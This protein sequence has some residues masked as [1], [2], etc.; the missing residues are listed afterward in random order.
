M[1][2]GGEGS[3][4]RLRRK[5]LL[6][7]ASVAILALFISIFGGNLGLQRIFV[8]ASDSMAP[9]LNRG[10]L[11]FASPFSSTIENGTLV[12]FKSP[13]NGY[14]T[15]RISGSVE[16]AQ[17]TYYL[18]KGDA[19]A[20]V[21]S[22]LIPEKSVIGPV[23][24]II[25][26]IGLFFM[27]PREI[28]LAA[29]IVA[30]VLYVALTFYF[31]RREEPQSVVAGT[32]IAARAAKVSGHKLKLAFTALLVVAM[33]V[34]GGSGQSYA[35]LSLVYP[36]SDA[37]A[38]I[39]SP[40]VVL[41]QGTAGSSTI[42]AEGTQA[43]VSGIFSG[44]STYSNLTIFYT[45]N[46]SSGLLYPKYT[47]WNGSAWLAPEG[48]LPSAG[49]SIQ[50][51][52]AA[53]CPLSSRPYEVIVVTCSNDSAL[54]AF[55]WNG[56]SWNI[57][58]DIGR[59]YAGASTYEAYDLAY[60]STSGRAVLVYATNTTD[61]TKDMAYRIWN[62]TAWSAEAYIDAPTGINQIK[63]RWIFLASN[64]LVGSNEIALI[65]LDGAN[66][67]I[68]GGIWNGSSW[69]QVF[70]L[71]RNVLNLEL[72]F[73][74]VSVAYLHHICQPIFAWGDGGTVKS[75]L[76]N[77]LSLQLLPNVALGGG[78]KVDWLSLK[79]DHSSNMIML[80]V[81]DTS[82]SLSTSLFDGTT[83]VSTNAVIQATGLTHNATRCAEFEWEPTG[84]KGL[85]AFSIAAGSVSYKTFSAPGTWSATSSLSNAGT[86]PWIQ[87]ERN[88][89]NIAGDYKI[90]GATLNNYSALY[91]FS[92]NGSVLS[93][94]ADS[95]TNNSGTVAYKCFDMALTSAF[96]PASSYEYVLKVTNLASSAL[97]IRLAAYSSS[98]LSRI[99]N[100]TICIHDGVNS[101][102]IIV[103][104]GSY[105]LQNGSWYALAASSVD[106]VSVYISPC[107]PGTTAIYAYLE[108]RAPG[109]GVL[110]RY[111]V[112]F[113]IA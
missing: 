23:T 103:D 43:N 34:A 93:L 107:S 78:K 100:L 32:S 109:C 84:S 33:V 47:M 22:I 62:G 24:T 63:T 49:S 99:T 42:S 83:W 10:D 101:S 40:T 60:E 53:Y 17:G 92:W 1:A 41:Q 14:Q 112:N 75:R 8:I 90:M 35:S 113:Y 51:L 108:V 97:E 20:Q 31:G 81:I 52:R 11:V 38:S 61:R 72:R 85:L 3:A 105:S 110:V 86:H 15:H 4:R 59:M 104:A 37:S 69:V 91:A 27:I 50:W 95:L 16:T 12:V 80:T 55:V 18:T 6:L 28:F 82:K 25:P 46:T 98:N 66:K 88:P 58:P 79:A 54:D 39:T 26:T 9:T 45:S 87:L 74:S 96:R 94:K 57:S 13:L 5:R 89:R 64:P 71:D 56:T 21:D 65:T 29:A 73:D 19:N 68:I 44:N 2:Y 7:L 102:Q 111:P 76:W 48:E 36:A 30:T 77:G 106:Y 67:D 70:D